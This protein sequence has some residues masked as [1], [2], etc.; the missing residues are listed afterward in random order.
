MNDELLYLIALS[1]IRGLGPVKAKALI[2]HTGSAQEVFRLKHSMLRTIPEIGRVTAEAISRAD[3]KRAEKECQFIAQEGIRVAAWSDSQYPERLKHCDDSPL[4]IY[5]RGNFDWNPARAISIVGTRKADFYGKHFCEMLIAGL[6]QYQ[7]TIISGLAH[8]ID[9]AA[10]MAA[11]EQGLPTIACVAHGLERIYPPVHRTL[12]SR[13]E[14][15]GGI[16]S[17]F[18]SHSEIAPEMF[19]MRNRIIAGMADCTIVVQTDIKG[20]SMIT[21]H[22]AHSYGR[23]VFAVPGR[24]SD[25]LSKGCHQLI[26]N[27]MAAILS[28]A[29]DLVHYLQWDKPTHSKQTTL[30][31]S[32]HPNKQAQCIIEALRTAHD[33]VFDDLMGITQHDWGTLNSLLLQLEFEGVIKLMPGKRYRLIGS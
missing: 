1:S 32:E 33:L 27:N 24:W 5:A 18:M 17:E 2:Q 3:F 10:H 29:E 28:S 14:K 4:L 30:V 26:K 19:P 21:A 7:P 25:G 9:G 31:F 22:I 15:K 6:T 16:V 13:M 20:G 11:V 12:A 8:G 23:D